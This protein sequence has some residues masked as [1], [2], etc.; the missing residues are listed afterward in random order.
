MPERGI[1]DAR[2]AWDVVPG[3]TLART[4]PRHKGGEAKDV[5]RGTSPPE[6]RRAE[7]REVF[8]SN[9]APRL[10][11]MHYSLNICRENGHYEADPF[12][13]PRRSDGHDGARILLRMGAP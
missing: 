9:T 11:A 13:A 10:L 6:S 8:R 3:T 12:N 2:V 7:A 1:R 5:V 4:L